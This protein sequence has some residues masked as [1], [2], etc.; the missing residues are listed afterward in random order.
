MSE[1]KKKK[2]RR[3][4][5]DW[6][7]EP[8]ATFSHE[9]KRHR[10]TTTVIK[11]A[12]T[13]EREVPTDFEPNGLVIY[14]TKKYAF[15]Y[16]EGAETE[17]R[18]DEML[19][20]DRETLLAPGDEVLVDRVDDAPY[21]RA[22]APRRTKLSRPG[23]VGARIQEQVIAA[24]I[25]TI[26]IVASSGQPRFKPGVVD[27]YLIIA[28][29]GGVEP[30]LCLNKIDLLDGEAP[31]EFE[32]YE[33]IGVRVV[34]TSCETGEGIDELRDA[35]QGKLAVFAGQSGVGKTSL[36]NALSPDLDLET[37]QISATTEK[38]KHTTSTARLYELSGD[39]RV[40]DTAGIRKL[41]LGAMHEQ[42]LPL[43][44]PEFEDYNDQCKFRNC[45]H[46]HE[47]D[48]AVQKAVESGDILDQRYRSYL[49]IRESLE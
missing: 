18:I 6:E 49:R 31:H 11:T 39:L 16:W 38:G 42:D 22:V 24:N 30:L 48:C 36:I 9:L 26:V 29:R 28:Q 8:D 37:R 34:R 35:L 15:V 43:Y 25:D 4:T 46:T 47:P 33:H 40:I 5:R 3:R 41:G 7:H 13:E 10:R 2:R 20:E 45:T 44:F 12:P 32:P 21:V 19:I 23:D 27:R 1:R 14:H 17:C